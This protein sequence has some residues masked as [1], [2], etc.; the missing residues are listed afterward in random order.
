MVNSCGPLD[1]G[2]R[3]INTLNI[4][5]STQRGQSARKQ[6]RFIV[7]LMSDVTIELS[8]AVH[9]DPGRSRHKLQEPNSPFSVHQQHS[10]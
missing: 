4:P 2:Q 5:T 10:L 6:A 3:N 9:G 8:E 7:N 1:P